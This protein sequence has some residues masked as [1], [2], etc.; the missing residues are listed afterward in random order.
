MPLIPDNVASEYLLG[1]FP[2]SWK[3]DIEGTDPALLKCLIVLAAEYDVYALGL[4]AVDETETVFRRVGTVDWR[5]EPKLFGYNITEHIWDEKEELSTILIFAM[6]Y[7]SEDKMWA[8][9]SGRIIH[10]T[11]QKLSSLKY[12]LSRFETSCKPQ[13]SLAFAPASER[14][15]EVA[16]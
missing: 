10:A 6:S 16:H 3:E 2:P 4:V 11:K 5:V 7:S 14:H 8:Y 9:S 15:H 13:A 1:Y 12:A